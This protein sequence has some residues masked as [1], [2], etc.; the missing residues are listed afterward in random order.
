MAKFL[1]KFCMEFPANFLQKRVFSLCWQKNF[2]SE[3]AV[4]HIVL[5]ANTDYEE[6]LLNG[7]RTDLKK[8][9]F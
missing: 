4:L 3:M 1:G 9:R 2:L 6:K 5:I 7:K 8:R